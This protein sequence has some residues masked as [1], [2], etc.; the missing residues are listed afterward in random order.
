MSSSPSRYKLL[1]K[2]CAKLVVIGYVRRIECN[3]SIHITDVIKGV[4]LDFL[5][6]N[7]KGIAIRYIRFTNGIL[8]VGCIRDEL[9]KVIPREELLLFYGLYRQAKC[10]DNLAQQPSYIYVEKRLKWDAWNKLKGM[11]KEEA[12]L[13]WFDLYSKWIQKYPKIFEKYKQQRYADLY[14]FDPLKPWT[15]HNNHN[16]DKEM[17]MESLKSLRKLQLIKQQLKLNQDDEKKDV[18][19]M[20]EA[21]YFEIITYVNDVKKKMTGFHTNFVKNAQEIKRLLK[22]N[23]DLKEQMKEKRKSEHNDLRIMEGKNKRKGAWYGT[24]GLLMMLIMMMVWYRKM[25]KRKKL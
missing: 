11:E 7:D 25:R 16:D 19:R 20:S 14:K 18:I 6:L 8:I 5:T 1:S 15:T 13:K 22:I 12:M 23:E 4:I 17:E 9:E 2:S 21:Q 10:G 3:L 24:V